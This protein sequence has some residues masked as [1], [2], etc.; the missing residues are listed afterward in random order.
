MTDDPLAHLAARALE[1][2]GEALEALCRALEGPLFRLAIRVLGRR[3]DARDATQ[4]ALIEIVTHLSQFRAESRLSTWAYTVATRRFL[5]ERRR[6]GQRRASADLADLI[7]A[8]LSA[9]SPSDV[10]EG[11]VRV[12][13]RETRLQ[14][15]QAML[16]CLSLEERMALVL[17]EVLGASDELGAELCGVRPATYRKRLSR[18]RGKLEP[19][20]RSLCG[21]ADP[22]SPCSCP[23]QARAKQLAGLERRAWTRLPVIDDAATILAADRLGEVQRLGAVLA[24]DPPIAPP[25]DLWNAVRARLPTLLGADGEKGEDPC[26][27]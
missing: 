11:E 23:R 21:L 13:A 16:D 6:W 7:R 17:A 3:E 9:T 25:E 26:S 12:L 2:D 1:G 5:R 14:C 4:E 18:A 10:P 20:L 27:N 24:I 8:G 19:I 22:T 15:T